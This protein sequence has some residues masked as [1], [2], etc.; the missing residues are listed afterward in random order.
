[1][2]HLRDKVWG[3]A[4]WKVLT[5]LGLSPFPSS[6]IKYSSNT[7]TLRVFLTTD[8]AEYFKILPAGFQ[9]FLFID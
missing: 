8:A 3:Y 4:L 2:G 6:T 7:H 5:P 1:M 9:R